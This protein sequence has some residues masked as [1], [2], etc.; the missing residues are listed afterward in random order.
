VFKSANK[1]AIEFTK[2][3]SFKGRKLYICLV[4]Q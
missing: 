3:I 2:Y 1:M 4:D